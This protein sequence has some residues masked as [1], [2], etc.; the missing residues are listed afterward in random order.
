MFGFANIYCD[1][2]V[3]YCLFL[4]TRTM[5]YQ[6]NNRRFAQLCEER[7]LKNVDLQAMLGM[8]NTSTMNRWRNGEDMRSEHIVTV[9]NAFGISPAEFFL[10]DEQELSA[11]KLQKTQTESV[12]QHNMQL[13]L[14]QQEIKF[15]EEI[16]K[17]EREHLRELMMKDV[18][19]AKRE[20]ELRE[21]IRSSVKKEYEE[22]ID[23]LRAQLIELSAQYKELEVLG[24]GNRITAVADNH[25]RNYVAHKG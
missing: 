9:C 10:L 19:L 12:D 8:T 11:P 13:A 18:E 6:F 25:G 23:R 20:V 7:R 5:S 3:I 4:H 2:F 1:Y 15:K 21:D 22:E 16:A 14:L 17:T 24:G